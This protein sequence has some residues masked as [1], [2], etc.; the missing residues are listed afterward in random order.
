[1]EI[2]LLASVTALIDFVKNLICGLNAVSAAISLI[3]IIYSVLDSLVITHG[4][5]GALNL[6]S[7]R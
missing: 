4:S 2:K 6:T 5:G 1:M 3:H 7:L